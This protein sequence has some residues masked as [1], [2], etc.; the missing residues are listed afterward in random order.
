MYIY[1]YICIYNAHLFMYTYIYIYTPVRPQLVSALARR[2]RR[3]SKNVERRR[4]SSRISYYI[5]IYIYIHTYIYIYICAYV[6]I[7][8]YIYIYI[9]LYPATRK[10]AR[11]I[12]PPRPGDHMGDRGVGDSGSP[13]LDFGDIG[14]TGSEACSRRMH[15]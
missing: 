11:G 5:Y 8:I 3:P 6:Y 1:I 10:T 12:F 13:T 9:V 2:S 14:D 4:D 7:Y 15:A